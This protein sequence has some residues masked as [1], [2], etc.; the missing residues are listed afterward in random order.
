MEAPIK[1]SLYEDDTALRCSLSKLFGTSPQFELIGAYP[2]ATSAI[3]NCQYRKPDVIIMDIEMPGISGIEAVANL[4]PSFH[5][6]KIMMLTVFEDDQ[7]VFQS[8]CNGAVGYILKK[9]DPAEILE[10]VREAHEG[11][12]PMSPAIATKVLKMFRSQAPSRQ[13]KIE[14][15][16]REREVLTLLTWGYSYKM[17]AAETE[18]SIDTVRFYIKKI[19]E[20]LHVHS[21]TE[22][23]NMALKNKW[24]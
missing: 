21:M 11:G 24:A 6:I 16:E 1:V 9:S 13:E 8:I 15:N 3:E 2:N 12:A 17:I 18:I 5:E 14:L 23:V 10:A 20:K 19:Y 4:Q 7:K 22:A